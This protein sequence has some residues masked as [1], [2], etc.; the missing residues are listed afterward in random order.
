MAISTSFNGATIY[1]PGS[2]SKTQIDLGGNVPLG[3]AGLVAIFGESDAG[4]P[5][6]AETD[7]SQNF[8]TADRLSEARAKY[9]SG[10]IVDALAF[11]FSPAADGAIPS[12][13][14]TVWVYK[15]NASLRA[16]KVLA[17][18]YG[19]VRARE[20]GVGG[21]RIT[22]KNTLT[23]SGQASAT[24]SIIA[25]FGAALDAK[26]FS[27]RYNGGAVQVVT[28][29]GVPADH[30]NIANLV[31]ELNALVSFN[32]NLIASASGN[33]LVIKSK[34][35]AVLH[36]KGRG[37]SFELID[38]TATHLAA[39]GHT[40]GMKIAPS[41]PVAT[42]RL[43]NKRD[44]VQETDA[45][46]GH[47][48]LTIGR[49]SSGGATSA[50]VTVDA[51]SI[52][53]TDSVATTVLDKA[54]YNTIKQ[55]AEAIGFV[56]GW[57]AAVASTVYNQLPLSALDRVVAAGAF[58]SVAAGQPARIKKDSAE[59]RAFFNSSIMSELVTPAQLGLPN[60]A[61]ESFLAGGVKGG[62]LSSDMVAALAKFEKFHCN[63]IV[64][65]FSRDAADDITDSLT[66]A[67]S[68]YTID[69]IHQA[70][71]T[72]ISLMK[73]TKNRS[74]RQGYLSM[75]A[76]YASCKEKAG[77]LA[78]SRLQL[79]IQDIRQIDAAGTIKWFQP[80]A[81]ACLVGGSRGGSPIGLPLTFKFMN[82]SGV[83]QT[84]QP[85]TTAEEDI[86]IDFDPDTQYD[87]AIQSGVTFL[88][89]P[90][91]GGFRIV[92]D[93]TTYGIDDNWV[94][95][96]ANVLYAADIVAFNF[97]DTMEKRYV[98]VKNTVRATEVKSTAE[99]VL[100]TFLAQGITVSTSDAP[101][102]FKDLSVRIDGNTI[103]I[104]VTIKLVEGIDFVLSDITLQRA[105]QTA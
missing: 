92:V 82:C 97:R 72:H 56:S 44:N 95:N 101:N 76:S 91:T 12:G 103:Y 86:V 10:P 58:A 51:T 55:L 96:R 60:A 74:E 52:T 32:T 54:A 6:S 63:S 43:D 83:R 47:V 53:L 9:R 70:V 38:S 65:L 68:S 100:S 34:V 42:V 69:G 87:D 40:V 20:W 35:D 2:Y 41:E 46:G 26:S 73:T 66:D 14:Q 8:Y 81:L 16:S 75:K 30:S 3:P 28:L 49:D 4:A 15:T 80:W 7:I 62:S 50:S 88:E 45:L 79:M 36:Q 105:T 23:N 93:N 71:K 18:S 59:V 5:G 19:T 22:Y 57:S 85:M 102:G 84:A 98:G 1:K 37:E 94:Y 13:A 77:D 29:S 25:T 27:Y 104:T 17:N 24:G 64:P 61:S 39:L 48:V 89:S 11:L 21:N 90:R 67:G 31:I 78:D 33:A 99:S